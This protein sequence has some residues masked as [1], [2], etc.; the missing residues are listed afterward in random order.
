[1]QSTLD[2]L[3]RFFRLEEHKTTLRQEV[4][5]AFTSFAT[6]AYAIVLIPSILAQAGMH[7][8]TAMVATLITAAVSTLF[9]GL[10]ANYPFILAPA[11]ALAAYFSYSVVLEYGYS[12]QSALAL[13]FI[14]AIFFLILN[15]L[16]LRKLIVEALPSSLRIG[17][18][19]G[20][21]LFLSIIALKNGS[22]LISHPTTAFIFNEPFTLKTLFFLI[23]L[24]VMGILLV[25]RFFGAIFLGIIVA[26]LLALF[27]GLIEWQGFMAWPTSITPTFLKMDFHELFGVHSFS[28]LLSFIFIALFDTSGTLV[29][30]GAQAG[31]INKKGKKWL[32]PRISRALLADTAGSVVAASLGTSTVA[33]YMESAAG[34]AE[35]GRTGLVALVVSFLFLSSLFFIPFAASLPLFA[36]APALLIIGA[37]MLKSVSQLDWEDPSEWLPAFIT[38]LIIP[39]T[40]SVANGIGV[41]YIVYVIM[42]LASGKRSSVHPLSWALALLFFLRFLPISTY[43]F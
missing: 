42:K 24:L 22:I 5:A 20:L 1:M 13:V 16:G 15:L 40:Y 36:T 39:L 41:G 34:I 11:V 3:R 14:V 27:T 26:W 12:W 25:F 10:Y 17:V 21:G 9:M 2:F 38:L 19:V 31:Y 28:I 29:A 33:V 7:F 32:F 35:G 18:S 43:F 4:V 30:L 6:L 23:A 37:L 8:E